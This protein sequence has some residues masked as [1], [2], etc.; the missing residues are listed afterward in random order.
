MNAL[1]FLQ[2]AYMLDQRIQTKLSFIS[3]LRA[4]AENV[5][6]FTETERVCRSRNVSAMEDTIIRIIEQEQE[7]NGEID[8]LV[9]LKK[10]IL[11]VIARVRDMNCRLIL[12]KRHLCFE[13][14]PTIGAEMGH[15]AR[16]AQIKHRMALEL[17]QRILDERAA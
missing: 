13:S 5:R 9:D 11:D 3:S 17:V 8:R 14:W 15:T 6:T 12:E 2:Q 10:E 7:V 4:L 16:W 1:D